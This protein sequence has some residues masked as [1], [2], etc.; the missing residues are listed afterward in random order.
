MEIYTMPY[1][2]IILIFGIFK[3][4]KKGRQMPEVPPTFAGAHDPH[5]F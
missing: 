2:K 1:V 4:S 5:P 3:K